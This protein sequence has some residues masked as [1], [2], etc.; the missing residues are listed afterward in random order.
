MSGV[1]LGLDEPRR[2]CESVVNDF[3]GVVEKDVL[4][5]L[6]ACEDLLGR[7]GRVRDGERERRDGD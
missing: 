2:A 1:D 3:E 4:R 6:R 7:W 5:E